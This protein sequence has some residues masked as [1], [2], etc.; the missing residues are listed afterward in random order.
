MKS[1]IGAALVASALV[2]AGAAAIDPAARRRRHVAQ[3]AGTFDASRHDRRFYRHYR[4]PLVSPPRYY[5]YYDRPVLLSAVSL[6]R[7]G[8]VH[9]RLWIWSI[10][11]VTTVVPANAGTHTA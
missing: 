9:V 8:A 6:F 1:L 3:T 11:V 4:Q 7:A 10:L 2:L 5:S